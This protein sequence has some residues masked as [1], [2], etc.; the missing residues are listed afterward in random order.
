MDEF[1]DKYATYLTDIHYTPSSS[2]NGVKLLSSGSVNFAGSDIPPDSS[3]PSIVYFPSVAG[4]IA[5]A[6]NIP[7]LAAPLTLTRQNIAD[8]FSGRVTTWADASLQARNPGLGPA[9][10]GRTPPPRIQLVVRKPGSGTTGN[11]VAALH[12]FDPSFPGP[13]SAN[14]DW[15]TLSN[16]TGALVASTNGAVGILVSSLP[17]AISYM[18]LTEV[19]TSANNGGQVGVANVINKNGDTVSPNT[20]SLQAAMS[21]ERS[22][23]PSELNKNV[24]DLSSPGAYPMTVF[25]Y[26][27]LRNKSIANDTATARWTLRYLYWTLTNG[28]SIAIANQFTPLSPALSQFSL[29]QLKS[30]TNGNQSL[31]GQS[32]CDFPPGHPQGCVNGACFLDLPFQDAKAQC[33]CTSGHINVDKSDCSESVRVYRVARSDA[34]GITSLVLMLIGWAIVGGLWAVVFWCRNRLQIKAISPACCW[35]LLA[36]C[37]VGL[38]GILPYAGIPTY[39]MCRLRVFFPPVAF[40][41]GFG[42]MLMKL[43]RIYLIFEHQCNY[44]RLSIGLGDRKSRVSFARNSHLMIG[45]LL[46][47]LVEFLLAGIWVVTTS[48]YVETHL[49]DSATGKVHAECTV[50]PSKKAL[51]TLLTSLLYVFNAGL[52]IA[53]L[54]MAF[55]T[56]RAYKRFR[57][58]KT[59]GFCIYIVSV[60]MCFGLPVLYA[61]PAKEE[62]TIGIRKMVTCIIIFCSSTG[63]ALLLFVPRLI[64]MFNGDDLNVDKYSL[65][66]RGSSARDVMVSSAPSTYGGGSSVQPG[67]S[68]PICMDVTVRQD[69][70]DATWMP[71]L[72]CIFPHVD[73]LLFL[74]NDSV[75]LS[76]KMS[77]VRYEVLKVRPAVVSNPVERFSGGETGKVKSRIML[78]Q[79]T[80]RWMACM[81][82]FKSGMGLQQLMSVLGDVGKEGDV[83]DRRVVDEVTV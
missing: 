70:V 23:D 36:G 54:L 4:A 66:A 42:M 83:V 35:V 58:S 78:Y 3:D 11:F 8:I 55:H 33:I 74:A 9:L 20:T 73:L 46:I 61:I 17:Y 53:C 18:D 25:T 49:D 68:T 82:E 57:E 31:Y 51:D 43:W 16:N 28:E 75:L 52:M 76:F 13:I 67:S 81:V 37:M 50:E 5:I 21:I 77:D 79:N 10:V 1:T 65:E 60:L 63:V 44:F 34:F 56:R 24:I 69:N 48:P 40:G 29:T 59:M 14:L 38:C 80:E 15:S 71:S 2:T 41:M 39:A 27:V 62:T 12:S 19:T 7:G 26:I 32:L 30:I 47:V 6:Y 64:E 22:V 45:T 72:L